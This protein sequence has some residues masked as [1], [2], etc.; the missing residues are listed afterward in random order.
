MMANHNNTFIKIPKPSKKETKNFETINCHR[1]TTTI[2]DKTK[3]NLFIYFIYFNKSFYSPRL[4]HH[5]SIFIM[6][7]LFASRAFVRSKLNKK[8]KINAKQRQRQQ[9]L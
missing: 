2:M 9:L 4:C 6:R 7:L 1:E 5:F 3:L 8:N